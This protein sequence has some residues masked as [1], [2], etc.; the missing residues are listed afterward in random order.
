MRQQNVV[1]PV[2]NSKRVFKIVFSSIKKLCKQAGA[3]LAGRGIVFGESAVDTKFGK[4][5]TFIFEGFYHK[6]LHR[7]K[8]ILRK[9][10]CT[11]TILVGYHY[12]LKIQLSS[13]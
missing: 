2:T 10:G 6:I 11:Q 9:R 3:W 1:L 5:N 13:Y 8:S 4:L 12:Q 7:P